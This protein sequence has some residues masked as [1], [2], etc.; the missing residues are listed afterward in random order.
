ML[1]KFV[2]GGVPMAGCT[3]YKHRYSYLLIKMGK[4][5]ILPGRKL[6]NCFDGC[7]PLAKDAILLFGL[8]ISYSTYLPT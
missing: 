6:M 7:E 1:E 8:G 3:A 5:A 2:C 4:R